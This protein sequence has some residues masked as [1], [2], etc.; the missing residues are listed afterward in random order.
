[1]LNPLLSKGFLSLWAETR[2]I[3]FHQ[4]LSHHIQPAPE[5]GLSLSQFG[6]DSSL[7]GHNALE[8]RTRVG[9]NGWGDLLLLHCSGGRSR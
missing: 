5:F 9:V 7:L 3:G 8:R 4:R 1:M 2:R 6:L